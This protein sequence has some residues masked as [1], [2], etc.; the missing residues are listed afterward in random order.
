MKDYPNPCDSC[1]KACSQGRGC[2]RW[3][4]RYLYRQKQ[5][6]L[7]TTKSR[8]TVCAKDNTEYF[9]YEHPDTVRE[10]IENGPC[11]GCYFEKTCDTPCGAYLRWWDVRME[12]LRKKMKI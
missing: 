4:I 2:E 11:K 7:Y 12:W 6:N 8:P 10:Y 3:R 9:C 5:I 1:E